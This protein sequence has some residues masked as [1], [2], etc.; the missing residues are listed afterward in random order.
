MKILSLGAG[1]QSSAVL[2]ASEQGL[3]PRLDA[4]I[5]ADTGWEPAAVYQHLGWLQQQTSIPVH[6]VRAG[7]IRTDRHGPKSMPFYI[8]SDNQTGIIR[9]QCTG[10]YKIEP[11][12]RKMR[13]LIGAK[14]KGRVRN[15]VE[16]WLGISTDEVQR[17]KVSSVN[18]IDNHYPLILD[19][20][21]SRGDCLSWLAQH[22]PDQDIP[23]SACIG[24]PFKS[25]KEWLYLKQHSPDEWQQ[26]VNFDQQHRNITE[27]NGQCFLHRS[28]QPL[29]QVDLNENQQDMFGQECTGMC[30]L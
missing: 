24:C 10:D 7:N 13:K 22:Y 25:D 11:V 17:A 6:V 3:L 12:R 14:K 15:H 20:K 21:W 26:A 16:Q 4:A 30:G 23:R 2:L 18:W 9:R 1:I 27:M 19:L 29:D 5:F 28:G 8:K